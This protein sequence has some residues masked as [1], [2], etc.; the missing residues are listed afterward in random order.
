[1]ASVMVLV[2]G[3]IGL[4]F[5]ILGQF[6]THATFW[7]FCATWMQARIGTLLVFG[8]AIVLRPVNQISTSQHA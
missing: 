5:A 7:Q 4:T 3:W 6:I 2:S 1:M 8:V